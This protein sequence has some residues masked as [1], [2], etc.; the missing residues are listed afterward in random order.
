MANFVGQGP[1]AVEGDTAEVDASPRTRVG[2]RARDRDGNEYIYLPGAASVAAGDAVIW[3]VAFG[4]DVTT[5]R[6]ITTSTGP[7]AIAMAAVGSG[8]Y[9]W[10]CVYGV[11]SARAA[12][13]VNANALARVTATDGRL[14]DSGTNRMIIGAKWMEDISGGALGPLHISYPYITG[15]L[16][17]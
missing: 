10:F 3:V 12:A 2:T 6:T 13:D 8:Q 17:A 1:L 15:N 16:G 4:T 14:D 11:C 5:G 9:G 7:I